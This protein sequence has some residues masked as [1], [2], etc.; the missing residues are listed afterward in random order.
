M[1]VIL[2]MVNLDEERN[3]TK[4][5]AKA[6][7][8]HRGRDYRLTYVEDMSGEGHLT[9][10]TM[11]ISETSLRVT[12]RG[13]VNSDFVYGKALTHNTS[14]AT[15]CGDMP[16]ELVTKV[17]DCS[18][19]HFGQSHMVNGNETNTLWIEPDHFEELPVGSALPDD[20]H[21]RVHI[22]SELSICGQDPFSSE[23]NIHIYTE[24]AED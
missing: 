21:M 16:I 17:F 5:K 20:F 3:E 2:E 14:Y 9:R 18:L 13:E 10:S 7:M 6:I 12:R 15:P 1:K 23:M 19:G 4:F 24:D 11:L 8:E 22:I